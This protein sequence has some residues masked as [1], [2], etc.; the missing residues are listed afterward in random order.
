[1][2]PIDRVL[3]RITAK[4]VSN[5]QWTARCPAHDDRNPSLSISVGDDGRVLLYC[6]R[7]CEIEN[8]CW[9]IDLK[10]SDLMPESDSSFK[11]P[12]QDRVIAK[13]YDYCD[14]NGKLLLQAVRYKPK[15]F[16]RRKPAPNGG[17]VWNGQGVRTVP[18]RLPE[19]LANLDQVVYVVEGEK[20][21]DTLNTIGIIATCNIGGAEKWTD[22]H[23]EFLRDRDVI[24]V[25]D[26]DNA[27]RKHA[28][29]VA[30]SL[31]GI[32]KSI[33]ILELPGLEEKGD[34][35]D[36]IEAGGTKEQLENLAKDLPEFM[37]RELHEWLTP[38]ESSCD[39]EDLEESGED[40]DIDWFENVELPIFPLD[41]LP[42]T[43]RD[44]VRDTAIATQTPLDLA[45][46]LVLAVCSACLARRIQV[47]ARTGWLK[48][49]NL[50]VAVLLEPGNR[51]SA[52]FSAAQRP[53]KELEKDLIAD[54]KLK[55]AKQQSTLRILTARLA[56]SEKK[57]ADNNDDKAKEEAEKLAATIAELE[58]LVPPQLIT[59]D[60]TAEKLGIMLSQQKGRMASM[61]AEGGVFDLMSGMYSKNGIPQFNIY[62]MGHA[63]DDLRTDRVSRESVVVERPALTCAY[64]IQPSVIQKIA[65]N[66]AFR[67][68]GLLARFLYAVPKSPIGYRQIAPPS[69][70]DA[71]NAAYHETVRNLFFLEEDATIYLSDDAQQ[72][73]QKWEYDVEVMLRE[74]G[75]LENIKDWGG[76]LVGATLRIAAILHCCDYSP[77]EKIDDGTLDSAITIAKYL[78]P[79]AENIH[80]MMEAGDKKADSDARYIL[81]WIERNGF[82]EFTKTQAQH[83]GKRRFPKIT[84]IDPALS[85][86]CQRGYI[87]LIPSNDPNKGPGRP[88]SPTY[89]VNPKFFES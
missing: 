62:L 30:E 73:L 46:L 42:A 61:S 84:D 17:W 19:L 33:K 87:R 71:V 60:A 89:E 3:E 7:G 68:R 85:V 78:I 81:R 70:S 65:E 27:G 86:L 5:D 72:L 24:V 77:F 54:A 50:F 41:V 31:Q 21:V 45:A 43:L 52:V 14:E 36:W 38:N 48:P 44:W 83:D 63:G 58:N 74:G 79:H 34:P 39:T 49:V 51:K 66:R 15:D 64:T 32:A 16:S 37:G 75:K 10:V 18:Y 29:K 80:I 12:K 20:D 82:S 9:A 57:A 69:V 1:M 22:E 2:T 53:L 8:I 56:K 25:P 55:V 28:L 76:K 11:S 35:S 13:T 59:D 23:A 88:P 40:W 4:K 47:E 6:H 67:G 26:N